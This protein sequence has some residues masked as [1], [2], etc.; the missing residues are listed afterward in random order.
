MKKSTETPIRERRPFGIWALTVFA[1]VVVGILPIHRL[2]LFL[3]FDPFSSLEVASVLTVA[4]FLI[5]PIGVIITSVGA[6][7]GRNWARKAMLV[8]ITVHFAL[9]VLDSV[10][11]DAGSEAAGRGILES[12][13]TVAIYIW[14]FNRA[15]VKRFYGVGVGEEHLEN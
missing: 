6:W 3:F 11:R 12:L 1:L 2:I 15:R 9:Q 10:V 4:F 14:Y 5:V 13:V 7:S 8:L